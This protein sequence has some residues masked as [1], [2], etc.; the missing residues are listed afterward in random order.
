M[1]CLC[2]PR[3]PRAPRPPRPPRL[4]AALR[5][6]GDVVYTVPE[7][8]DASVRDSVPD[9]SPSLFQPRS[10]AALSTRAPAAAAPSAD[11]TPPL[12]R[13]DAPTTARAL[14]PFPTNASVVVR[15]TCAAPVQAAAEPPPLAPLADRAALSSAAVALHES[16]RA[17][18]GDLDALRTRLVTERAI[19]RLLR[20]LLD[21]SARAGPCAGADLSSADFAAAGA[22]AQSAARTTLGEASVIVNE[23]AGCL[24]RMKGERAQMLETLCGGASSALHA[25]IVSSAGPPLLLGAAQALAA[26]STAID[27]QVNVYARH[28]SHAANFLVGGE[29][30]IAGLV[31]AASHGCSVAGDAASSTAAG[32]LEA[33]LLSLLARSGAAL[34]LS[35]SLVNE[36]DS[37]IAVVTEASSSLADMGARARGIDARSG[38]AGVV[39]AHG[40]LRA[41]AAG[42]QSRLERA[43]RA[44][45]SWSAQVE[46]LGDVLVAAVRAD[47]ETALAATLPPAPSGAGATPAGNEALRKRL[48]TAVLVANRLALEVGAAR[49][50]RGEL[51]GHIAASAA[52]MYA[53]RDGR[54]SICTASMKLVL[55]ASPVADANTQMCECAAC[56]QVRAHALAGI[57]VDLECDT[58]APIIDGALRVH[59]PPPPPEPD[60]LRDAQA[61]LGPATAPLPSSSIGRLPVALRDDAAA[62]ARKLHCIEHGRRALLSPG[63]LVALAR[64][65]AHG[66]A[67]TGSPRPLPESAVRIVLAAT[68]YCA[69]LGVMLPASVG[70]L[71]VF[72]VNTGAALAPHALAPLGEL[73]PDSLHNVSMSCADTEAEAALLDGAPA[74]EGGAAAACDSE[75][76]LAG[77]RLAEH[78]GV[79]WTDVVNSFDAAHLEQLAVAEAT[80]L[81]PLGDAL[82]LF[83]HVARLA[84]LHAA[85]VEHERAR[86]SARSRLTRARTADGVS[87]SDPALARAKEAIATRRDALRAVLPALAGA[88][89]HHASTRRGALETVERLLGGAPVG[90][91]SFAAPALA[92]LHAFVSDLC[93]A[94]RAAAKLAAA[95]RNEAADTLEEEW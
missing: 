63:T 60:E 50:R 75:T 6:D 85:L 29:R 79:H 36:A 48:A 59:V 84:Q 89:E 8:R 43:V 45:R 37:T 23:T 88:L 31:S 51:V 10:P 81:V 21:R 86:S 62:L 54:Q 82:V 20:F 42:I 27:A 74:A 44:W 1:S 67:A 11:R 15:V 35:L 39:L 94:E 12:S 7:L 90:A 14:L 24:A 87:A 25:V 93:A 5:I 66:A 64:T 9:A 70:A 30:A 65:P 69:P 13:G 3:A 80:T 72:G 34:S 71:S 47:I 95:L 78:E 17:V 92:T 53:S 68:A 4:G 22:F 76:E 77:C 46:V 52:R 49:A 19:A 26:A 18:D 61:L 16:L 83:D 56:A 91:A 33:A 55:D 28:I 41:H 57:H 38:E 32:T 58:V 2:P 73:S 40:A